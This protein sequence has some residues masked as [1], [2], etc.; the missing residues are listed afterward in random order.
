MR[1]IRHDGPRAFLDRAERWLLGREAENNLVL[2]LADALSRST[3]GY[4]SPLYFATVE[5]EGEVQGCVFRTPPYKLGLTRMPLHAASSVAAAVAEVYDA[6]PAVLGPVDV[7]R[8]VGD[9]WAA[10]RGVRAVD[11]LR[12]RIHALEEVR[13]PARAAPGTMR[14]AEEGDLALLT[15]WIGSFLEATGLHD[16]RDPGARA[17]GL[18]AGGVLVLWV[19]RVP[20]SMAAFPAR[21][22]NT[23]RIGYV[24]TPP[25][26]RR[27]GY[28]GTLVSHLSRHILESGFRQCVLYTDLSNPTSNRIYR[29]IGYRPVQDVMDVDFSSPLMQAANPL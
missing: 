3:Q 7:A 24:Y 12:Q 22:R 1:V 18:T 20:V 15:S 29:E 19:D 5:D 14:P 27:R 26:Y 8:T 16:G 11:G 28:A 25:E 6:L 9:A 2:G 13:V 23:V 17:A 4:D 21:T 10:A